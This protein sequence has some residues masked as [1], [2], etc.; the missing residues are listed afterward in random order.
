MFD[1]W[2]LS[3]LKSAQVFRQDSPRINDIARSAVSMALRSL[4]SSFVK[5]QAVMA[6]S[7]TKGARL[8]AFHTWW[9][10]ENGWFLFWKSS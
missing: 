8:T 4:Y 2:R 5:D 3:E 10:H 1:R 6:K 9:Y 7:Y